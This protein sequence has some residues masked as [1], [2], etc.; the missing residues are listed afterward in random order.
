MDIDDLIPLAERHALLANENWR[1]ASL[2]NEKRSY[3]VPGLLVIRKTCPS[4]FEASIYSP[5]FCLVL[6]GAKETSVGNQSASV[7]AGEMLLVSHELPVETRVT[8][9]S[10]V[11]PYL[12]VFVS[13]DVGLAR[14][15]LDQAGPNGMGAGNGR[16]LD[17]AVADAPLIEAL[18]RYL[19]L[20]ANSLEAEIIA[21]MIQRE[22]HFRLLMA[23]VG[24]MLR[25]L[26]SPGG[27]ASRVAKA[28]KTIR[29]NFRESLALS[30]LAN[31]VGMS[32]SS[33]HS[34]F[35]SVTGT[36]PLQYQKDLRLISAR[37]LLAEGTHSVTSAALAVGYESISQFSREYSRKF[38][39]SPRNDLVSDAGLA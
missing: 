22:I 30:V 16:S 12:A 28:I 29:E 18:A 7:A 17:T 10:P 2:I 36:T 32:Q 35:K 34:N 24:A 37:Q 1:C 23:P 14:S 3:D 21:P 4:A 25:N 27:H 15:L 31:S 20:P 8:H 9:A 38:G 5:V 6:Q 26:L 19:L 11:S 39:A 13:I 33:F